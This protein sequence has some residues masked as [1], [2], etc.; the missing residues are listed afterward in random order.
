MDFQVM[1]K[2]A[3]AAC[4]LR[5]TYCFYTEKENL[6]GGEN[7]LRMPP[8]VLERFVRQYIEAQDAPEV[9]FAWQ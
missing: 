4:N 3:G 5:C 2:P 7:R 1:V 8:E 9:H 6:Y